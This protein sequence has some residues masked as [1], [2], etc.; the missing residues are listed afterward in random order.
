MAAPDRQGG[1][2]KLPTGKPV[3]MVSC[4]KSDAPAV[5]EMVLHG[6][7]NA[8]AA[9]RRY[10]TIAYHVGDSAYPLCP[11]LLAKWGSQIHL[12]KVSGG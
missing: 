8:T 4:T 5:L 9:R 3:V 1:W 11:F 7:L 6:C 10:R 2:Q 12:N